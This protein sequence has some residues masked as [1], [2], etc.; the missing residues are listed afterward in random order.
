MA[1]WTHPKCEACWI[2]DNS[3]LDDEGRAF[4]RRP[5]RVV[6]DNLPA[7]VC[8]FCG[9]FTIGGIYVRADPRTTLCGGVH[10]EDEDAVASPG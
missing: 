3:G 4:I 2:A 8:C 9:R 1:E 7:E 6:A 10:E 5:A